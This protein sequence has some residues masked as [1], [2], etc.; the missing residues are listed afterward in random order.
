MA[1]TQPL[2]IGSAIVAERKR[3]AWCARQFLAGFVALLLS[4]SLE[5]VTVAPVASYN[6][7][8]IGALVFMALADLCFLAA[9]RNGGT[10]VRVICSIFM[11]PTV[12]V[13]IDSLD[14][15]R[16]LH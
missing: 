2:D 16:I 13:V 5:T 1:S 12:F 9:F 3:R 10:V 6:P 8:L 7:V 4:L 14:R 15:L 11:L